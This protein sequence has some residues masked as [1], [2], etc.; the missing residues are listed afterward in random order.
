MITLWNE[1]VI[2]MIVKINIYA[3][4]QDLTTVEDA[5]CYL[6]LNL[7]KLEKI[8]WAR[9]LLGNVFW[10]LVQNPRDGCQQDIQSYNNCSKSTM[11]VE[12][13]IRYCKEKYRWQVEMYTVQLFHR[14]VYFRGL[15][16]THFFK[17]RWKKT[18]I[19]LGLPI[20][21]RW[22][23]LKICKCV[24]NQIMC[25]NANGPSL[26]Q[27]SQTECASISKFVRQ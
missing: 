6:N 23:G 7:N 16:K 22:L 17:S 1:L 5:W 9:S 24:C 12:M 3:N 27:H 14:R 4:R 20:W 10:V 18:K 8:T 13:Q 21:F 11:Q 26:F 19:W 15:T 25:V 2:M